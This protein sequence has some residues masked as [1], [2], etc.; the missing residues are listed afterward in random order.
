MKP[1]MIA[2]MAATGAF[3]LGIAISV[4]VL[5]FLPMPEPG[6]GS[7]IGWDPISFF[8]HSGWQVLIFS[9]SLAAATFAMVYRY[10]S[11]H[12]LPLN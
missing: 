10:F 9:V 2:L 7:A 8:H 11:R 12:P 4:E 6:P 1:W 5:V 3:F